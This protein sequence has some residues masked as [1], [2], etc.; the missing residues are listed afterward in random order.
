MT[1]Y[2]PACLCVVL[3]VLVVF[4]RCV[5]VCPT[6]LQVMLYVGASDPFQNGSQSFYNKVIILIQIVCYL[7]FRR[8]NRQ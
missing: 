3:L 5:G 4:G 2:L 1:T 6:L 7:H 8:G